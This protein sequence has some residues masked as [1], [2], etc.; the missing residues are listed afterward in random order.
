MFGQLY[1]TGLQVDADWPAALQLFSGPGKPSVQLVQCV[2]ELT[3]T[4]QSTLQLMLVAAQ[5]K[6][7]IY[8][9][10]VFQLTVVSTGPAVC[11]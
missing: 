3:Q 1:F 8:I 5:E 4:Q 11:C 7:N 6:S 2:L 9:L 10:L